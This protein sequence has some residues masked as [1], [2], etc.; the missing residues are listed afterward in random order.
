MQVVA[1]DLAVPR[2]PALTLEEHEPRLPPIR[3]S[4]PRR[5]PRG[6][7]ANR[8][9]PRPVEVRHAPTSQP[10]QRCD[11]LGRVAAAGERRAAAVLAHAAARNPLCVEELT[12]E[13]GQPRARSDH[14][15]EP[16]QVDVAGRQVAHDTPDGVREQ[17]LEI[18]QH[19]GKVVDHAAHG[20]SAIRCPHF[21][22]RGVPSSRTGSG[23]LHRTPD[24]GR[25]CLRAQLRQ[26]ATLH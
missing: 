15:A 1:D 14:I 17:V 5:P 12:P 24:A 16:L 3:P 18:G 10:G 23:R 6:Q 4:R 9:R 25:R 7:L 13:H 21:A 22:H 26:A 8:D 19:P 2:P 11:H 20:A